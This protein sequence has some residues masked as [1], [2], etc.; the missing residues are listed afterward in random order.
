MRIASNTVSDGIVRQIQH[1]GTQQARLQTQ[2]ATGLRISQPEDDPAAVGRVLNLESERRQLEQFGLNARRALEVSQASFSG[3]QGMIKISARAGEL[4]TLGTGLLGADAM[5][6]YGTEVDQLI[7]QALQ[8]G[9]TRFNGDYI[10]AG[11]AVDAPPFEATRDTNGKI[12]SV[13][14]MGNAATASIPLSEASAITPGTSGAT[15]VGLRDFINELV[16]LR[17]ALNSGDPATVSAL[18]NGLN[19]SEDT[20]VFAVADSAGIQT[21]IEAGRSQQTDRLTSLDALVSSE[22]DADL[23]ATIV[24]LNQTQT[25]YQAALQSGASL[26]RLS[27]LDYI[28]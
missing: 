7:E 6:A 3:L 23:P 4:A 11:T 1:L 16:A 25:A 5:K 2:V 22:T 28:Q 19:A 18:Q 26:M 12:T 15:N 20:L 14:Y 10:Y 9:N 24:R 13:A 27:L 21:R 17:D 8:A